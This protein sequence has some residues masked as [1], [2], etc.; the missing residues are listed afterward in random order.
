[1]YPLIKEIVIPLI[2]PLVAVLTFILFAKRERGKLE[3]QRKSELRKISQVIRLESDAVREAY[4]LFGIE[5]KMGQEPTTGQVDIIK[6]GFPRLLK[7]IK[8]HPDLLSE[9]L[10]QQHN[11]IESRI[12][13]L[14][15]KAEADVKDLKKDSQISEIV[16]FS[17]Y[18]IIFLFSNQGA[19]KESREVID[20]IALTDFQFFQT[21][22]RPEQANEL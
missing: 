8:D 22:W 1:M 14:F 13:L 6:E 9:K 5:R 20:A 3:M 18:V 10:S 15:S 21:F 16:L 17:L 11:V 7:S 12:F 2:S 19:R 4:Q